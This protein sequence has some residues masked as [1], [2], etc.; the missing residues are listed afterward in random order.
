MIEYFRVG[1]LML[2]I[3]PHMLPLPAARCPL[4]AAR[5]PLPAARIRQ[6]AVG[7]VRLT[8]EVTLGPGPGRGRMLG[9]SRFR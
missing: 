3:L 5:C 2:L 6:P 4:P 7:A 1:S 8:A 9:R